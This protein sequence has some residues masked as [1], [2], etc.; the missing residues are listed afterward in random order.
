MGSNKLPYFKFCPADWL[1]DPNVMGMSPAAEGCYIRLLA[2]SWLSETPGRV[3]ARLAPEMGGMHRLSDKEAPDVYASVQRAF[4]TD[5]ERGVWIQRRM[6]REYERLSG[7]YDA[8]VEGAKRTNELRSEPSRLPQRSPSQSP[9][10]EVRSKKQEEEE[11]KTETTPVRRSVPETHGQESVVDIL[12]RDG[13]YFPITQT[14]VLRWEKL[15]PDVLVLDTLREMG[16][17][18]EA[19]PQRRKTRRGA[20]RFV[21]GWLLREQNT[22][23]RTDGPQAHR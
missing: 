10:V 6:V 8:R 3:P 20:L 4:D 7:N 11:E 21:T 19:N 15:F 2:R 23:R 18:L 1:N 17:W 16:A 22:P 14:H 13:S 5:S 12:L 9:G